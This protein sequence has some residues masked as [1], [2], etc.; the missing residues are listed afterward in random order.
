MRERVLSAQ[1]EFDRPVF[2]KL[3]AD[4]DISR[5]YV[6]LVTEVGNGLRAEKTIDRGVC[7]HM[8][9]GRRKGIFDTRLDHAGLPELG[10]KIQL[11]RVYL[12]NLTRTQIQ[13]QRTNAKIGFLYV[14]CTRRIAVIIHIDGQFPLQ[15]LIKRVREVEVRRVLRSLRRSIRSGTTE[16]RVR[17]YNGITDVTVIDDVLLDSHVRNLQ[18]ETEGIGIINIP[19]VA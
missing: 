8:V 12:R 17:T 6:L 2:A 16:R 10:L 9:I 1:T 14:L 5:S 4:G 15:R 13:V 18:N 3:L 11:H 7:R 19:I